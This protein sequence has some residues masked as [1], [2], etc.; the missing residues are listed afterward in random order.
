VQLP[1]LRDLAPDGQII[2]PTLLSLVQGNAGLV[3]LG[4]LSYIAD[5][6]VMAQNQLAINPFFDADEN[7]AIDIQE[8]LLPNLRAYLDQL[9]AQGGPFAMYA[10]E[11]ALPVVSEHAADL[12]LPLLILQGEN[13]A[14]VPAFGAQLLDVLLVGNPDRTLLLYEGLGHSLGEAPSVVADNFGPMADSP[15]EDLALWLVQQAER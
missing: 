1:Y 15:V 10:P 12:R 3:A 11:R 2:S 6:E 4:G 5:P 9:F 7:G 14:N 13:D 8:E